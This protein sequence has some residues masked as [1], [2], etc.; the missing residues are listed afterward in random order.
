MV[1]PARSASQ[2]EESVREL[3][4][5]RELFSFSGTLDYKQATVDQRHHRSCIRLSH[6]TS[7]KSAT[8]VHC[9]DGST[10]PSWSMPSAGY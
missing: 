7:W 10:T 6:C 3:R 2:L 9:R 8:P 1:V 5:V 4:F